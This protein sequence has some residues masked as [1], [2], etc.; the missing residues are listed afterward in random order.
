VY[1]ERSIECE[2]CGAT[3]KKGEEHECDMEEQSVSESNLSEAVIDD[4]RK[5]VKTKQNKRIKLGDG[6]QPRIDMFTASALVQVHDALNGSNQK[7]FA[8][9]IGKNENMFMKMVDFAFS[10]A[11][12]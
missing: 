7:K 1:E 5:I 8:D 12:K 4:L 10:K 6:T 9:A 2:E 11:K 3:Y